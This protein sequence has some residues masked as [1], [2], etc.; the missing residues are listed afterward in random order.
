MKGGLNLYL[1]VYDNPLILYDYHGLSP[2]SC[3]NSEY[4]DADCCGKIPTNDEGL[5]VIG[6]GSA[7]STVMCC[8]GRKISC[9]ARAYN[10]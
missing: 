9:V 6:G 2:A 8:Q 1:Y 7:G 5:F 10:K 3:C 4:S